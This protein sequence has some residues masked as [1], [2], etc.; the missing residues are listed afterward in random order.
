MSP[1]P[2]S[3]RPAARARERLAALLGD[4][5]RL[6]ALSRLPPLADRVRR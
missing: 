1:G 6:V 5:F 4:S 3:Q 2:T